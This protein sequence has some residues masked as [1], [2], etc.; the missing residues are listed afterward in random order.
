MSDHAAVLFTN[1]SFYVAFAGRDLQAMEALWA[2][3]AQV[4]CTHPGWE[5]VV[6]REDVL[7]TWEAIL[8]NPDAPKIA[9]HPAIAHVFGDAAYVVCYEVLEGGF[10]AATNVFVR[11]DGAWRMVHHQAGASPPP[12]AADEDASET[13]Q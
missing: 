4:T 9:C 12:T 3:D 7:R 8:G 1:E 10:L 6:G 2:R 11:E 13:M 5:T